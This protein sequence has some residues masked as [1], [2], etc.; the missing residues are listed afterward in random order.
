MPQIDNAIYD[1]VPTTWWEEDG[2]MAILRTSL[3]PPRFA[4]FK[5]LLTERLRAEPAGMRLLDVGCGGGLLAEAFAGLGCTVAGIDPSVPTLAAARAHAA[6]QGLAIDYRHGRGDALP[7]PDASFDIVTCCDVLEHVDDLEATIAEI[8]RVLR[9]GGI[10]L[11]DTIN[12]TL[13]SKLVAIRMAQDCPLT[14]F[15]PRDVHVWDRFI[16]PVELRASLARHALSTGE[17]RGLSPAFNP[18]AAGVAL[19]RRKL[20]RISYAKLGEALKLKASGDLSISYM[21]YAVRSLGGALH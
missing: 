19:L 14:R 17:L 6:T 3:N 21:G 8:S 12:R 10:F 16:K 13:M 11:F 2:F 4:Y 15:M 20:G 9:P 5:E 7:F 18:L 1:H